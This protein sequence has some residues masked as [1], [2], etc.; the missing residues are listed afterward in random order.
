MKAALFTGFAALL[1]LAGCSG[2]SVSSDYDREA[3]FSSYRTFGWMQT[4]RPG[5]RN[6]AQNSL[7]ETRIKRTVAEQ[8]Q[9]MGYTM[10][11]GGRPDIRIALHMN[12]Q[13]KV[14]VEHYGYRRWRGPVRTE[15]HHYK[16]GTLVLDFVDAKLQQL[17]WRG[18]ANSILGNPDRAEKQINAAVSKILAEYPPQ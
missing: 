14:E 13:N 17:V 2:I 3:D 7:M 18:W 11:D 4:D 12:V 1:L 10:L 8:L 6:P 15:V 16:E 5:M 9:A